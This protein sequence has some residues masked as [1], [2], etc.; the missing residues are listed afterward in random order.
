MFKVVL[1]AAALSGVQATAYAA[2][3]RSMPVEISVSAKGVDFGRP[4][5]VR[6]M[7][8]K[9]AR[10]AVQACDSGETGILSMVF[11]DRACAKSALN[12]AVVNANQP[13]LTAYHR[14]EPVN[15][16]TTKLAQR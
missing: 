10:A 12:Q 7:H 15:S 3:F 6:E 14:G 16:I 2:D 5:D 1:L 8:A 11:S 9:L 13:L 4:T